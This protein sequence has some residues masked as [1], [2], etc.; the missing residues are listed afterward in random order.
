MTFRN[1]CRHTMTEIA[2]STGLPLSTTHRLIKDLTACQLLERTEE[3]DYRLGLPMRLFETSDEPSTVDDFARA[4][5]QDLSE[6]TGCEVRLGVLSRSIVAFMEKQSGRTPVPR[7][8]SGMCAPAHAT[9]MGKVLLAFS[10]PQ[11]TK[12]VLRQGLRPYTP[13]TITR[14]DR[15]RRSLAMIR[16]TQIAVSRSELTI[17]RN[18]IAAPV[19]GFGGGIAAAIEIRVDDISSDFPAVTPA[20]VVAGRCLSRE[21]LAA[22]SRGCR[23]PGSP[24]HIRSTAHRHPVA[25]E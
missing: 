24:S 25:G 20:L 14:P 11:A 15:L 6:V 13:F 7:F 23:P 9:A 8:S 3:G 12:F 21:L 16:Q 10:P 5:L 18:A 22:R 4:V 17:G 2:K 1:G 19:F